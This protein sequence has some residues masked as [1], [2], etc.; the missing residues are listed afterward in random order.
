MQ[1]ET[2]VVQ[3]KTVLK[4]FQLLFEALFLLFPNSVFA[5]NLVAE[6]KTEKTKV[7][8]EIIRERERNQG[9]KIGTKKKMKRKKTSI[10]M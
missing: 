7:A 9:A 6:I 8:E 3:N 4:F 2:V 1:N 10:I 5:T